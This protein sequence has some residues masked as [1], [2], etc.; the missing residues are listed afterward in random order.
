MVATCVVCLEFYGKVA[1]HR[2]AHGLPH[3][4]SNWGSDK[5][6]RHQETKDHDEAVKGLASRRTQK[7]KLDEQSNRAEEV[8]RN[9]RDA[10]RLQLRITLEQIYFSLTR[11]HPISSIPPALD[12]TM[13]NL[14]I[15]RD[16]KKV[17]SETVREYVEHNHWKD[18]YKLL[19]AVKLLAERV[20]RDA[21]TPVQASPYFGIIADSSADISRCHIYPT[22]QCVT[23]S[24]C[25]YFF[26]EH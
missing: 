3:S 7:Q 12:H 23:N 16:H 26:D 24:G 2:Y 17:T 25:K 13:R 10:S 6:K 20:Q 22:S 14:A 8:A 5:F 21:L 4:G 18:W 9:E 19:D 1:K 11:Q 15:L